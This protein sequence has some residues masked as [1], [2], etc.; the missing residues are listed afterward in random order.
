MKYFSET[1]GGFYSGEL[2]TILPSDAI[3]I[4]DEKWGELLQEHSQGKKIHVS[5]DS[6]SAV[7]PDS[8]LSEEELARVNLTRKRAKALAELSALDVLLPRCVEDLILVQQIDVS[9]L[10]IQ[11]QERLAAKAN[12]R[13]V[14]RSCEPL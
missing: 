1:T 12:A 2:H 8:L 4:S 10:P 14:V 5:N 7:D 11:M 6:V 13:E 9:T 3:P